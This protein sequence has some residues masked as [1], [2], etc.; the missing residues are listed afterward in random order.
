MY[1]GITCVCIILERVR[2]QNLVSQYDAGKIKHWLHGNSTQHGQPDS[3]CWS[4]MSAGSGFIQTLVLESE[5]CDY[6]SYSEV[7]ASD[8]SAVRRSDGS[9]A[10]ELDASWGSDVARSTAGP[11]RD[12]RNR[13]LSSACARPTSSIRAR[14]WP[15]L[16]IS[17]SSGPGCLPSR[18][19][20]PGGPTL[21]SS[22]AGLMGTG[23]VSPS[24]Q[25]DAGV[26]GTGSL[27]T[28]QSNRLETP[29]VSE[30]D[31]R[32]GVMR[33]MMVSMVQEEEEEG[34][35]LTSGLEPY[36]AL[37]ARLLPADR[38]RAAAERD[39]LPLINGSPAEFLQCGGK[40]T[41]HSIS[42]PQNFLTARKQPSLILGMR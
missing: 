14:I 8:G 28:S 25:P 12:S 31:V 17:S 20:V 15:K 16:F 27:M 29:L 10:S 32:S 38:D 3:H 9:W 30:E 40:V 39:S 34:G 42:P 21:G 4:G 33:K 22:V 11:W 6:E 26:L 35:Y 5:L 36:M 23:D 7:D 37:P 2:E 19:W 1:I 13:R 18:C 41:A 24:A